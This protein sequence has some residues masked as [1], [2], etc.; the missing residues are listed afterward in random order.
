M[1][2]NDVLNFDIDLDLGGSGDN[3]KK[4]ESRVE[5]SSTSLFEGAAKKDAGVAK[6]EEGIDLAKV[7]PEDRQ[8][9]VDGAKHIGK[10]I[11]NLH[12]LA[13]KPP[14]RHQAKQAISLEFPDDPPPEIIK[15]TPLFRLSR[16]RNLDLYFCGLPIGPVFQDRLEDVVKAKALNK[17][18]ADELAGKH[19]VLYTFLALAIPYGKYDPTL[20]VGE[21]TELPAPFMPQ[22]FNRIFPKAVR[23]F[24]GLEVWFKQSGPRADAIWYKVYEVE[25]SAEREKAM[26]D[27][28]YTSALLGAV[29]T[30]CTEVIPP[31][32]MEDK[33]KQSEA[34][35]IAGG[36]E[37]LMENCWMAQPG[38]ANA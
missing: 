21:A 17:Y 31:E 30:V 34:D 12:L 9:V 13:V 11:I 23:V 8:A 1:S 32:H 24:F 6:E 15:D 26:Q 22:H 33:L 19:F 14:P 10:K 27:A 3:A 28:I 18:S 25:D 20:T 37:P 36:N 16:R 35:Y 29:S 38:G 5:K 7:K 4:E 2:E